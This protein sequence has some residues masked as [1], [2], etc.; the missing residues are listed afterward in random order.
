MDVKGIMHKANRFAIV[1]H[2]KELWTICFL[3]FIP[4]LLFAIWGDTSSA[5]DIAI[6]AG[7]ILLF[8]FSG[9][10]LCA[11]CFGALQ[12]IIENAKQHEEIIAIKKEFNIAI[13]IMM[14]ETTLSILAVIVFLVRIS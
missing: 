5:S 6:T 1:E 7:L 9:H 2:R 4:Q 10:G 3:C 14:W 11:V 13:F 8:Q 12:G